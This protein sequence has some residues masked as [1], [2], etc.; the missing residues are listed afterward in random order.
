MSSQNFKYLSLLLIGNLIT[1]LISIVNQPAAFSQSIIP[2]VDNTGTSVSIN[3]NQIDISGGKTSQDGRNLFHSFRE[4]NVKSGETANFLANPNLK[5]ILGRVNGG[6]ASLI[7]GVLQITG[8]TPNLW[9]MN[10]AGIIFGKNTSLNLP[11]SLT[12]TTATNIGFL[13]N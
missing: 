1:S 12:V 8:G 13:N 9:L 5:N 2:A 4:F 7:N 11:A 6:S 10:P 3:G